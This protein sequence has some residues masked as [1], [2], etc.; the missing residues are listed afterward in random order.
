MKTKQISTL[1]IGL[2]IMTFSCKKGGLFCHNGNGEITTETRVLSDFDE[3]ELGM[4]GTLYVTQGTDYNVQV[5]AS[6]NL[7]DII[8]TKVKNDRL[9]IEVKNNKC[10]KSDEEIQF[11]VTLPTVKSLAIS[12]SG[13][14]VT[15]NLISTDQVAFTISGSG[16]IVVDSLLATKVSSTISGSGDLYLTGMD[17]VNTHIATISGSGKISTLDIVANDSDVNISGSGECLVNVINRLEVIISGSGNVR[18]KG[19]PSI[20]TNIS[21]SGN[22]YPY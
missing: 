20:T 11:F 14:I 19:T 6:T 18:Y 21:G 12:G 22:I 7:M 1:L 4:A 5:E 10:L 16:D 15:Q 8:E 3:I 2:T 17:T 13:K 9:I